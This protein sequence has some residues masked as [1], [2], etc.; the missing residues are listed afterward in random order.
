MIEACSDSA[1]EICEFIGFEKPDM[2]IERICQ[3]CSEMEKPQDV[4]LLSSRSIGNS[5]LAVKVEFLEDGQLLVCPGLPLV[6]A[7]FDPDWGFAR[8]EFE[9]HNEGHAEFRIPRGR[10][11]TFTHGDTSG[12]RLCPI[13]NHEI[14]D[15]IRQLAHI[16]AELAKPRMQPNVETGIKVTLTGL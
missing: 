4:F 15:A 1:Q 12:Y 6:G 13:D 10:P 14:P 9:T 2:D 5:L 3:E 8:V 11:D 7:A 16:R